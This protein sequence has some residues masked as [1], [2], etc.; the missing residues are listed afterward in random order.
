MTDDASLV[1]DLEA[2]I[3]K[4][5]W[6]LSEATKEA[7]RLRDANNEQQFH[8]ERLVEDRDRPEVLPEQ[9]QRIS[10]NQLKLIGELRAEIERLKAALDEILSMTNEYSNEIAEIA[11]KALARAN[12]C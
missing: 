7:E 4:L 5:E 10:E 6:K 12:C 3:T 8:I 1:E 9:V 11:S 2:E